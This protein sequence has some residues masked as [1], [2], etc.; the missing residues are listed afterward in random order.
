MRETRR[1]RSLTGSPLLQPL[2]LSPSLGIPFSCLAT[3]ALDPRFSLSWNDG[4]M[5]VGV[6]VRLSLT[7]VSRRRRRR[8]RTREVKRRFCLR[9]HE[10]LRQGFQW[11]CRY[12]HSNDP[13]Q[14]VRA[15]DAS[16]R[17]KS[18]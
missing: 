11:S 5:C 9:S 16:L 13:R 4:W 1:N 7:R 17:V 14:Q 15:R 8:R 12:D 2:P 10:F 6:G 3:S 18:S